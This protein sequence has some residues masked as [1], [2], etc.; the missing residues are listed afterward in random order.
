MMSGLLGAVPNIL[1]AVAIGAVGYFVAK[2]LRKIVANLLDAAGANR[3]GIA[4][5]LWLTQRVRARI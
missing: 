1:A 4:L 5:G 2:Q 3:A